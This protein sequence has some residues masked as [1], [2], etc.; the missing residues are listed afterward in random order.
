MTALD[1][2]IETTPSRHRAHIAASFMK[3]EQPVV[4]AFAYQLLAANAREAATIAELNVNAWREHADAMNTLEA[5]L[6]PSFTHE[7]WEAGTRVGTC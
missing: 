2:A 4:R 5:A 3:S 7:K 6:P 1:D